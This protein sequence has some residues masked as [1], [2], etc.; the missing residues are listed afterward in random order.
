M[1]PANE[2]TNLLTWKER[3]SNDLQLALQ[4]SAN[5]NGGLG[6]CGFL[7]K[8]GV[9]GDSL[10][11]SEMFRATSAKAGLDVGSSYVQGKGKLPIASIS[12][13]VIFFSLFY[14]I[15]V[16]LVLK[17]LFVKTDNFEAY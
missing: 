14:M 13:K 7:G 11:P 3:A 1:G 10:E 17:M 2:M 16:L 9:G 8:C 12:D 5:C 15:L 4:P 6:I